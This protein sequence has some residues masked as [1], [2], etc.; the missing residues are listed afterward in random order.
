[1]FRADHND[2]IHMKRVIE[3]NCAALITIYTK[4]ICKSMSIFIMVDNITHKVS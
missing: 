1:M 4:H 2:E 3:I